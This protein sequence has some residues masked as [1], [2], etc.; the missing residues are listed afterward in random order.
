[1]MRTSSSKNS[2]LCCGSHRGNKSV[3]MRILQPICA[4]IVLFAALVSAAPAVKYDQR[5]EGDVNIRAD[6]ENFVILII[7]TSGT[8][9]LGL[10]DILSKSLPGKGLKHGHKNHEHKRPS[11]ASLATPIIPSHETAQHFIESKTA[12]YHVD[13]SRTRS[14]L[15]KLHPQIAQ[16]Q[17]N[18][19]VLI[20]HSP[21]IALSKTREN[22]V[23]KHDLEEDEDEISDKTEPIRSRSSR[24]LH[25]LPNDEFQALV[26]SSDLFVGKKTPRTQKKSINREKNRNGENLTLL[27]AE[28]DQC[29]PDQKRDSLGICQLIKE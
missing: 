14:H 24:T 4:V 26:V 5:Q 18:G 21:T 27:G 6:L 15:A 1:M 29:G 16:A 12:P 17:S 28:M 23:L 11:G 20:A 13:I 8:A 9:N 3:T 19:E 2:Q 7:P 25:M 10:L 22:S